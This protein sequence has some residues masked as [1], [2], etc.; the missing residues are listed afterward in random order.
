MGRL[1]PGAPIDGIVLVQ[2]ILA[3]A[4]FQVRR[5]HVRRRMVTVRRNLSIGVHSEKLIAVDG[6]KAGT[7][8]VRPSMQLQLPFPATPIFALP[9]RPIQLPAICCI[10]S[11]FNLIGARLD[12][13]TRG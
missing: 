8:G 9:L 6:R 1:R 11:W 5:Q 13:G 7:L 12:R 4:A 10:W 3:V 2:A